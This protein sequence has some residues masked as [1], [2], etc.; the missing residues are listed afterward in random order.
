MKIA[1]LG[2]SFDPPHIGHYLVIRQILDLRNDIGKIL[3]VPAFQHQWKPSFA[4]I[5]NRLTMT[6]S[7]LQ[8][9]TEISK[10][11]IDR[12]GISYTID[13][14]R[15]L[16][17]LAQAQIYWVVGSDIILEFQKWEKREELINL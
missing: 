10:I 4:S 13:T 9:K 11:E 8:E 12:K 7:L 15:E 14:I 1:V 3:L 16:K 5:E 6:K 17:K 2:G